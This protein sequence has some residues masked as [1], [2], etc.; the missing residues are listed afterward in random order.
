MIVPHLL[1]QDWFYI[2]SGVWITLLS[3]KAQ[4]TL[5]GAIKKWKHHVLCSLYFFTFFRTASIR[6]LIISSKSTRHNEKYHAVTTSKAGMQVICCRLWI[7]IMHFLIRKGTILVHK[8]IY[9][10]FIFGICS[11]M[12]LFRGIKNKRSEAARDA[13]ILWIVRF[14]SHVF[15]K[16]EKYN[17]HIIKSSFRYY[18][19][20]CW[21]SKTSFK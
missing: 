18:K 10:A 3:Q 19:Q 17:N 1:F 6:I 9:K 15:G 21:S 12:K 5:D 20:T 14:L 8:A 2:I 7:R 13:F 16:L 11:Y 4:Y